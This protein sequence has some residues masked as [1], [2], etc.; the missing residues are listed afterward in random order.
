LPPPLASLAPW[1]FASPPLGALRGWFTSKGWTPLPFQE[2]TWDAY[3]RGES[4]LVHVPTGAGKT[5]AATI[6]AL[7]DIA[8]RGGGLV[9]LSPLRAMARDI[10]LALHAPVDALGLPIVVDSRTGD[11]TAY[12][13]ARQKASPPNVLVT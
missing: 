10:E 6:A 13:R 3:L 1:R 4:G 2:A 5:Y 11:T 8:V 9:Y 12:R 7:A